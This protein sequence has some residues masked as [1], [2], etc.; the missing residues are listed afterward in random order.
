MRT[1]LQRFYVQ[2]LVA[3]ESIHFAANLD[4]SEDLGLN[5][6]EAEQSCSNAYSSCGRLMVGSSLVG[7]YSLQ[8]QGSVL[9]S[10]KMASGWETFFFGFCTV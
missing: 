7:R 3:V 6:E 5:S 8:V 4:H 9:F 10:P 2:L 1:N